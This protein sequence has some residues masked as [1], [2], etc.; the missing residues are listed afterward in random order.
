MIN[1]ARRNLLGAGLVAASATAIGQPARSFETSTAEAPDEDFWA[2]IALQYDLDGRYTVLNGG[3]NNPLPR[4][5][6][7][8][9]ARYLRLAASQPRPFNYQ[10]LAYRERHRTRLARLFGCDAEE[11]ALTRNTTEGLNTVAQGLSWRR[12]DEVL[13]SPFEDSYA[14]RAFQPI[15]E[16]F[17]INL[18]KAEIPLAPSRDQVLNGFAEQMSARTRLLVASHIV[19]SWGFVLPVQELAKLAHDGGAQLLVDGALSF[20]HIPVNMRELGCDYYATSLHKWLN[21]PL[22]TGALYVR[23]DRIADLWPLYGVRNDKEDIRKYE[24]I[25]TRDGAAVAAIGQA[26]DF[27]EHIGPERKADRL[28]ALL[29]FLMTRLENVRGV[30]VIGEADESRRA[31]LARVVVD[32]WTG[33]D[34]TRTLRERF[35]FYVFGN[36]PGPKDGVYVSPNVFNTTN[37][38]TRFS[39]AINVL[40]NA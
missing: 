6:V 12:G 3:G 26:I 2:N 22:G 17:G 14:L 25:G 19:D 31:G 34:L 39:E 7:E 18:V 38:L 35:G 23:Q 37:H 33:T 32:G 21:A 36:F 30:E 10:L 9:Q 40:S 11:L 29:A 4:S 5:V 15:A 1:V 20:G 8:A 24:S 28:R 27:Y 13:V 16:R